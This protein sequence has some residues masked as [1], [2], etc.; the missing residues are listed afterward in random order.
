MVRPKFYR[1]IHLPPW[2]TAAGFLPSRGTAAGAVAHWPGHIPLW[3][4]VLGP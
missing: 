1:N 3:V 4:T 2:P